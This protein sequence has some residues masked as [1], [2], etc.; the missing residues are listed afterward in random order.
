MDGGGQQWGNVELLFNE[1][2]FSFA[3]L[4]SFGGWLHN[5]VNI[6]TVLNC[7]LKMIKRVNFMLHIFLTQ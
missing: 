4:K 3:K 6:L 5:N 1:C 7:T 2:S